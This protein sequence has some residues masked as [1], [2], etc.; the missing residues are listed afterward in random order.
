MLNIQQVVSKKHAG[1]YRL[2]EAI[3]T[4]SVPWKGRS[5]DSEHFPDGLIEA[6]EN[7]PADNGV[8]DTQL[9][10]GVQGSNPCAVTVIQAMSGVD[11]KPL[12]KGCG[13]SLLDQAKF[14]V[15]FSIPSSRRSSA[16]YGSST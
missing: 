3:I 5:D 16:R 15:P 4:G 9:R 1:R 12:S 10:D 7:R 11:S 6:D 13:R 14:S 8:A 2:C